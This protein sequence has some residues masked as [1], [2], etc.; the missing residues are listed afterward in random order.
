MLTIAFVF[1]KNK[2]K[3]PEAELEI[4]PRFFLEGEEGAWSK[5]LTRNEAVYGPPVL[6][7]LCAHADRH[8]TDKSPRETFLSRNTFPVTANKMIQTQEF[9]KSIRSRVLQ[10]RVFSQGGSFG[11]H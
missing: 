3:N 5:R 1:L 6:K 2:N 7:Y 4:E 9:L 10:V 11:F 8:S